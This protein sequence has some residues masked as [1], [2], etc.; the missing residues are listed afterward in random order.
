[1]WRAPCINGLQDSL[2]ELAN[3]LNHFKCIRAGRSLGMRTQLRPE[4]AGFDKNQSAHGDFPA[5]E[6]NP[7]LEPG[8]GADAVHKPHSRGAAICAVPG[9]ANG[10]RS[11]IPE[12]G[13]S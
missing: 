10:E 2:V 13:P 4:F 8:R 12:Y 5:F 1:M 9:E 6:V 11:K 7:Q 3:H